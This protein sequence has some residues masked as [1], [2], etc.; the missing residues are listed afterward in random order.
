M[1]SLNK[2]FV[3]KTDV[4]GE[5]VEILSYDADGWCPVLS[6]DTY[7][8]EGEECRGV[9]IGNLYVSVRFFTAIRKKDG[10]R[11]IFLCDASMHFLSTEGEV[12]RAILL[13]HKN[14]LISPEL[15]S[16]MFDSLEQINP[17]DPNKAFAKIQNELRVTQE[18]KSF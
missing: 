9:N 4:T 15:C 14:K 12:G 5:L 1:K 17:E 18:A 3:Y 8:F 7:Q 11:V 16:S 6:G 13:L 10:V 2:Q